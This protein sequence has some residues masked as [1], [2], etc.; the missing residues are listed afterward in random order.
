MALDD[1]TRRREEDPF[2]D[3]IIGDIGTRIVANRSRFE[4]D[5]NRPRERA[6]YLDVDDAWGLRVWTQQ[7]PRDEWHQSLAIHDEFYAALTDH[8]DALA[9]HG[10]FLVLDVH[11]YNHRRDGPAN[12]PAPSA[13]NPEVNVGTGF[14]DR[15]RWGDT[16]S[17]FIEDL[18]AEEVAGHQLDVRENVRFRG[19]YVSQWA[20]D[21]YPTSACTL[22]IEFKK[23]FMDEWTGVADHQHIKE[24]GR[25]LCVV[26]QR[27]AE[28][29]DEEPR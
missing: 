4:V 11:A 28:Q 16:V 25:S 6:V 19:G 20:A 17:R 15:T 18:R 5:L 26:A 12:P 24:L 7:L 29:L 21:R 3:L 27:V 22:A 2:T 8:F 13:D 23:V 14:L 1:D 10:C 9:A